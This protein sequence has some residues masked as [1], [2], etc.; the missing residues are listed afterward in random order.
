M[1]MT[2]EGIG[3]AEAAIEI[4]AEVAQA[5][6][7]GFPPDEESGG[8]E[9]EDAAAT[10]LAMPTIRVTEVDQ[11]R[12]LEILEEGLSEQIAKRQALEQALSLANSRSAYLSHA[13]ARWEKLC[14]EYTANNPQQATKGKRNRMGASGATAAAL[15]DAPC[16]FDVRLVWDDLDFENWLTTEEG[17]RILQRLANVAVSGAAASAGTAESG[18][19]LDPPEIAADLAGTSTRRLD[20]DDAADA[21][22]AEEEGVVCMLTR[23]KCD[24]HTGWQKMREADFE[25]EKTVLTRRLDSLAEGERKL[26]RKIEDIQD[27]AR[28][29]ASRHVA[30]GPSA[31]A[32]ASTQQTS[33]ETVGEASRT[34]AD[35]GASLTNGYHAESLGPVKMEIDV[36][37][38][39]SGPSTATATR[40]AEEEG[41]EFS[42]PAVQVVE[43]SPAPAESGFRDAEDTSAA[44]AA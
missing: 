40:A 20:D 16:G 10:V 17:R 5:A 11:E 3:K 42:Q 37:H 2:V 30:P 44:I 4:L 24:R 31:S 7:A 8:E 35:D 33:V 34:P 32:T 41:E 15:A 22:A 18:M 29:R 21:G 23:R 43:V 28:W 26:R 13:I 39:G 6:A 25:V 36:S 14:T 38:T 12:E 1:G 27:L 9:L 19:E